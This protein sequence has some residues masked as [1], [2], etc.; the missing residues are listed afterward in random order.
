MKYFLLFI[1]CFWLCSAKANHV[2]P[3]KN[4]NYLFIQNKGQWH[5]NVHF[6]A[7]VP[8]G[9]LFFE[10][11]ALTYSLYDQFKVRQIHDDA[12]AGRKTD[13]FDIK[14]TILRIEFMQSNPEVNI[15]STEK[16]DYYE[17]YYLGNDPTKWA[18]KAYAYHNLQYQNIYPGIQ[19]NYY[20]QNGF[21]KYDF[22]LAPKT[23]PTQI[24][25]KYNGADK[26]DLDEFGNLIIYTSLNIIK[27]EKPFAYQ[28]LNG[29]TLIV[30]AE[31]VLNQN[32]VSFRFPDAYNPQ[33]PLT[34]DPLL[35]FSTYSGSFADNF[36]FTATYDGRGYLY[37]GGNVFGTGYSTTPGAFMVNFGAGLNDV[38]IT[39]YDS[40]GTSLIFSTYL[41]GTGAEN[42]N[43]MIVNNYEELFVLGTTGSSDFPTSANAFDATFNGGPAINQ[44]FSFNYPNGCDMFVSRFSA[45]G[46]AL[47]ASTYLGGTNS[48]GLNLAA[49]LNHN[50]A[51]I[52][53]GEIDIDESNFVYIASTTASIDFPGTNGSFQ[54]VNGGGSQDGIVV[55]MD[56]SLTSVLWA[57]YLGGSQNDAVY[58]LA[59]DQSNDII[60][61]GGTNSTNFPVTGNTFNTYGGAIDG[62]IVKIDQTGT[63]VIKSSLYGTT[64][65]DQ[66]YFVE[67]DR[68]DNVYVLGQTNAGG[69]SFIQNATYFNTGGNQFITKFTTNID[70]LV[71]S[72]AFG[73]GNGHSDI[74]PTAFLVDVCN[75]IYVSGWGG[76]V[77]QSSVPGCTTT[78][79][80]IIPGAFQSNTDG[81]DFYLMVMDDNA[82]TLIYSTFFGGPIS[83]EHVDGGTSR[84]NRRGEIYQSVC[85]GCGASSD[86]PSFP[87]NVWSPTNNSSNC[88]NG[89]F[90]F[91]FDFPKT[92]ADFALPSSICAPSTVTFTNLSSGANQYMWYFED[93]TTSTLQN[94]THTFNTS[95]IFNIRLVVM[96]ST[97]LTCNGIDSVTK[98]ITVIGGNAQQLADKIVCDGANAPIGVPP[99]GDPTVTY[100][101]SPTAGLSDPNAPNPVYNSSLGN[102]QF[103]CIVSNGNCT[104][105]LKQNV[106][107]APL[108][109][110]T[111]NDTIVCKGV[112][113]NVGF[114]NPQ[115]FMQFSWSPAGIFSNPNIAN[116]TV[117]LQTTTTITITYTLGDCSNSLTRVLNVLDLG[118]FNGI[119]TA[120]CAGDAIQINEIPFFAGLTYAWSPAAGL[121]NTNTNNP[122]ASPNV[123]TQYSLIISNGTCSDTVF[124]KI[125]VITLPAFAG[126][127]ALLCLG[128]SVQLGPANVAPG[129]IYT[130]TPPTFLSASN[131]PN[132]YS[133]PTSNTTY[134]LT[135]SSASNPGQCVNSDTVTVSV[136]ALPAGGFTFTEAA[137]CEGVS[138]TFNSLGSPSAEHLWTLSDGQTSTAVNPSFLVAY[139]QD[140]TVTLV[141][142]YGQCSDSVKVNQ[143][144]KGF[145][146]YFGT[147][148]IPNIFTPKT[149]VG[150]NDCF[151]PSGIGEGC[152]EMEIYNRWG[153][154]VFD[155]YKL[156][157]W[158]WD[159]TF[160]NTNNKVTDGVY[161]YI[162]DINGDS[163]KGTVTIASN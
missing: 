55:K 49:G 85:A 89:V 24:I 27:E 37:A 18:S 126:N 162:I 154:K 8:G 132:P 62:F 119:D 3:P 76:S 121:S 108:P 133:T 64:A 131:I 95:G 143:T 28:I 127:D 103:I 155:S 1:A 68:S 63:F 67:C 125:D 11:N 122:T 99:T 90:K 5:P 137:T 33:L 32:T 35:I 48:D 39:K 6:K 45:D 139:N 13:N 117:T 102:A 113:L 124:K 30:K 2:K 148:V 129:L 128:D 43:S 83:A 20:T 157:K 145:D 59:L 41:G 69:T 44:I 21:L 130:W 151:A 26:L 152:Y 115:P 123:S 56:N 58:S 163:I 97:G 9:S 54:P 66:V 50:Y 53:R 86:F 140:I 60:V 138:L 142:K 91:R 78:G 57:S 71:W 110:L 74:S 17:N 65:Y 100:T 87:A 107:I 158:C 52:A 105:T 93:G 16:S 160:W 12:I 42:P 7:D 109:N 51:D 161:F 70:T 4:K 25:M 36:G 61:A 94:P 40:T 135:T 144:I 81:S 31:F 134:I 84:F 47:N 118:S 79:L 23:D 96:D 29:D 111:L 34:I 19:L 88:N 75:K 116:P 104:D 46:T 98:Q 38:A 112:T 147:L 114:P 80:N 22:N 159:G 141:L 150:V 82:A 146:H 14:G 136:F 120:I 101:W 10:K 92:I 77:N 15:Q 73:N 149:T 72:T 106:V 153:N 156:K